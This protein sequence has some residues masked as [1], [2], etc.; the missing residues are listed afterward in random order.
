MSE[1]EEIENDE[2]LVGPR[3]VDDGENVAM[4]SC[5][6]RHLGGSVGNVSG[7]SDRTEQEKVIETY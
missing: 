1:D 4:S 6:G 5:V 7:L 2:E 3:G